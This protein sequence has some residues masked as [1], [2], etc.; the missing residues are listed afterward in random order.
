MDTAEEKIL[1]HKAQDAV[2]LAEKYAAMRSTGFLDPK[3]QSVL[4]AEH[5]ETP[6][7]A[8]SFSGGYADAERRMMIV[9]PKWAEESELPIRVIE[10][11]SR[12]W[13][14]LTHRDYLGS[15]LGLGLRREKIGDIL[16]GKETYMFVTED[17]ADYIC[18]NLTRIG[19]VGVE[20]RSIRLP[21]VVIPEPK[22]L[23]VTGSVASLRL[24]AVL[25]LS[26]KESRASVQKRIDAER[27]SV[28]YKLT[29]N[30][31]LMLSE[32]DKISVRGVGKML[33]FHIGGQ[34]KKGRLFITVKRYV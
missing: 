20:V 32:G 10:I 16:V 19:N 17:I 29:T 30:S 23:D 9:T 11:T 4:Y 21:E 25:A 34:S 22:F 6:E 1:I 5:L 8:I 13:E 33:L 27:V 12:Y 7:V 24:D 18:E 28:N 3:E 31:S 14:K 26:L 15:V 2:S